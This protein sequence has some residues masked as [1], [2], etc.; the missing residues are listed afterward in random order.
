MNGGHAGPQ[1][2]SLIE[3]DLERVRAALRELWID[4]P[5]SVQPLI[6]EG[7]MDKGKLLRPALLLLSGGLFGAV[8]IDHI[9]ASAVLE[10]VHTASL[11]HDDVLDQGCLRRGVP[12]VNRRRGNRAAV[13]LGD[14]VLA[15]AFELTARLDPDLR[16]ALARMVQQTC[17]GEIDQTSNAGDFEITE[18]EYLRMLSRKTAALFRGAC[19]LGARLAGAG[20]SEY[21]AVSRFGYNA[22]MAY[23]ITDDLLD[24]TGDCAVLRKTLGT[25]VHKAKMTLPVIHSLRTA[26]GLERAAFLSRLAT[27]SPSSS[28]LVLTLEETGS[29]DY[30]RAQIGRYLDRAAFAL[31]D[32]PRTPMKAALIAFSRNCC[33]AAKSLPLERS[34]AGQL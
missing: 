29:V 30:A 7:A 8:T 10:L 19:Y 2:L 16:A 33:D 9:H 23:Q 32:I 15:K 6:Q 28:Q 22:G 34:A 26:T 11:L 27:R 1:I 25:D 14:M 5:Q 3:P 31:R 24:I 13:L 17:D 4:A 21:R 20:A 18:R 12:T